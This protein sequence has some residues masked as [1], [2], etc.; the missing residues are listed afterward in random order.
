MSYLIFHTK[1]SQGTRG[2]CEYPPS[3]HKYVPMRNSLV[4]SLC[5]LCADN[6]WWN[7]IYL[8]YDFGLM[9]DS[10]M[11]LRNLYR[12]WFRN[13]VIVIA[14]YVND[15][16]LERFPNFRTLC[17]SMHGFHV[18][19]SHVSDSHVID[20]TIYYHTVRSC[21]IGVYEDNISTSPLKFVVW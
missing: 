15:W 7:L 4:S 19:L 16:I 2:V 13:F 3:E 1:I 10:V 11:L 6:F 5:E 20:F 17:K 21:R 12:R 14:R 18:C 8:Q 9:I